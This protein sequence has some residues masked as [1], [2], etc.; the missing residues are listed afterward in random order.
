MKKI[1]ML[2][3]LFSLVILTACG[4]PPTR[5]DA[6]ATA[7]VESPGR[8]EMEETA[9]A[10]REANATEESHGEEEAPADEHADEASTEEAPADEEGGE[11]AG[12]DD[13]AAG[14]ELAAANGCV[15]CHSIDGTAVVGPSWQGLYES[16]TTLD[17]G[18]TVVAD[19][20]YLTESI[21][22]PGAKIVEGYTNLMPPVTMSEAEVAQVVE[23]IKSVK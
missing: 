7:G 2:I 8:T 11:T 15:A 6:K 3:S 18:T 10:E 13:V 20:E 21:T 5:E 16:E 1:L 12:G 14:E 4:G 19:E 23:Y 17:D 9:I 22:D